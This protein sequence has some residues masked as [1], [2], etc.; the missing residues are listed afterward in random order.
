MNATRKELLGP[1]LGCTQQHSPIFS[2]EKMDTNTSKIKT[3]THLPYNRE[4]YHIEQN[5]YTNEVYVH[6]CVPI[7]RAWRSNADAVAKQSL[8]MPLTYNNIQKIVLFRTYV[9]T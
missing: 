3:I 8:A 7:P 4:I 6:Y 2:L 5:T 1:P 9:S